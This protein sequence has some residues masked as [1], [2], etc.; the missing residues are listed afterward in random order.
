VTARRHHPAVTT[1]VRRL[2]SKQAIWERRRRRRRPRW[3][4]SEL[5]TK[6]INRHRS[7]GPKNFKEYN[8]C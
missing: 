5:A 2:A 4:P 7:D 1:T 6:R 3:R 8:R